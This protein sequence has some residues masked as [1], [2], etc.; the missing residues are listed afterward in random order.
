[1]RQMGLFSVKT[2]VKL[3]KEVKQLTEALPGFQETA[4]QFATEIPK[5]SQTAERFT[6]EIPGVKKSVAEAS[7]MLFYGAVVLAVGLIAAAII[8]GARK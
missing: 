3:P 2:K 8:M 4:A 1:M 5:F 7:N 6:A